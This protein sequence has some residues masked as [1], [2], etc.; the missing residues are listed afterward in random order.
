MQLVKLKLRNI[1]TYRTA[2]IDFPSGLVLLSGDIGSGKSTILFAVEFALFGLLRGEL[3][4]N[5][6]LRNGS[7]EGS[8]ELTFNVSKDTITISRTLK[9]TKN[10]VEQDAGY[11]IIN[12]VKQAATATELKSK[13]L[14]LLGYPAELLT[15]SKNFVYRYTVYTP[16]EEMKR[17]LQESKEDR[18]AILRK[19]FNIDKYERISQNASNYAK[20]LRERK[21]A[22]D[23]VISDLEEK[24]KQHQEIMKE[25]QETQKQNTLIKPQLEQIQN[26]LKTTTEQVQT[27]E[28]Q[29]KETEKFTRT[30]HIT[31]TQLQ[32]KEQQHKQLTEDLLTITKQVSEA[33]QN[34]P[35]QLESSIIIKKKEELQQQII[36]KEKQIRKTNTKLA[37]L[38]T[39]KK[40]SA[41]L[42]QK[43]TTLSNCPTCLQPVADDHKHSIINEEQQKIIAV[44]K[45][46]QYNAQQ[47]L[48][49]EQLLTEHKTAL[50]EVQ[51]KEK[52]IAIANVKIK[53]AQQLQQRKTQIETQQ[54]TTSHEINTAQ[55]TIQHLERQLKPIQEITAGY[56]LLRKEQQELQ[57]Q[58]RSLSI[59]YSN[60]LQKTQLIQQQIVKLEQEI[61]KKENA[62]KTLQRTQH[63][64]QWITDYFTPL[65]DIIE[66]HVMT[67]I[68]HEFN[69]VFQE[70]F[71]MLVEDVLSAKLND[72]FTPTI[73]QN[74]YDL[75]VEHLSGGEKTACAL[76]YRL[77]LNKTI[78]SLIS[79][80]Q[81]KDL[82]VL[83][84][85]TDGFSSEQLDKMRDVLAQLPL[86]QIVVVSHEQ[87]IE[88][89]ADQIIRV[90]KVDG[91]SKITS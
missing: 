11:L 2:E 52:E 9:R 40:Q 20:A 5:A 89:F 68:H 81:T 80:I 37:E 70:W 16:Q 13:I 46:L 28:L 39:L 50:Q 60:T 36:E 29:Q 78:N 77:A 12:E 58:E 85:P 48:Q 51:T 53:H 42:S 8:V 3:S 35:N 15:K 22:F 14:E 65:M 45:G 21:R 74:G 79:G 76:A 55:E 6:L 31:K 84:E 18:I 19:V 41:T 47:M 67:T 25:Y 27:I 71:S 69:A 83:D 90:H 82:I 91:E 7:Q 88:S 33:Q 73:Q 32:Q 63:V 75:E 4:G 26:K 23:L 38:E 61:T 34:L 72:T 10:S 86:N 66:K 56:D 30:L 54:T 64:H 17:I 87:K 59:T 62:K 44:E 43:I 49:I 24:K 57:Q 1:R